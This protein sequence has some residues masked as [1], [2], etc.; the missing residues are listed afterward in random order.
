MINFFPPDC[1]GPRVPDHGSITLAEPGVTTYAA[2]A[3]QACDTGYDITG[4]TNIRCT[5]DATWSAPRVVCTIRSKLSTVT[6]I[7][8][9]KVRKLHPNF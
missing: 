8:N 3:T 9:E 1:S 5:A 2:T 4:E 6:G 7:M